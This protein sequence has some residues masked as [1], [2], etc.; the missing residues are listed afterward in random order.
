LRSKVNEDEGLQFVSIQ[1][2]EPRASDRGSKPPPASLGMM[3]K[4]V[5][6]AG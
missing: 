3:K 6:S 2:L 5:F 4:R 1:G